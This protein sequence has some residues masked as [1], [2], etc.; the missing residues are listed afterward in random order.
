MVVKEASCLWDA[1][2]L[3]NFT[4]YGVHA[5]SELC[6]PETLIGQLKSGRA[7]PIDPVSFGEQLRKAVTDGTASF[8]AAA[9]LDFVINQYETGFKAGF[10]TFA[11]PWLAYVGMKWGDPEGEVL[12]K[13]IEYVA[14]NVTTS[15]SIGLNCVKGNNLS[16]DMKTKLKKFMDKHPKHFFYSGVPEW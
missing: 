4:S 13:T 7:P 6:G 2:A 15:K 12:L 8:T 1:A 16:A 9:D 10:A 5:M 3:G 14:K 11:K